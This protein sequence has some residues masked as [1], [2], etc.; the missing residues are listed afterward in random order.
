MSNY[1][2]TYYILYYHNLF[3]NI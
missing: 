3:I 2:L 1:I